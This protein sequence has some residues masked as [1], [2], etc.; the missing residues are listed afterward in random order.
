MNQDE[1]ISCLFIVMIRRT[2]TGYSADVPDLPGCVATGI[3][4]EQ[5]KQMIEEA[6]T[7]HL[8]MM[9]QT[10]EAIPVPKRSI[11]FTIDEDAG[12]EFCGWVE[13]VLPISE[14]LQGGL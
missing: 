10:G 5:T 14:S 12:E 13:V 11:E 7:L 1:P 2:N 4:V 8:D 9:Q 6:I 3:T